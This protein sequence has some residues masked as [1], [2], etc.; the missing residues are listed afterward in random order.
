MFVGACKSCIYLR[1]FGTLSF[2]VTVVQQRQYL[3]WME[4][5][6]TKAKSLLSLL[7]SLALVF[8]MVPATAF[9]STGLPVE[10]GE[11]TDPNVDGVIASSSSDAVDADQED[12]FE[13]SA[14]EDSA[15]EDLEEAIDAG[16]RGS[17]DDLSFVFI[18]WDSV[19]R[20]GEQNIAVGFND[21]TV[22]RDA[23]LEFVDLETGATHEVG[24]SE[25]LPGALK[26][27]FDASSI[28]VGDYRISSLCYVDDEGMISFDLSEDATSDYAF[29]IT[30]DAVEIVD[31]DA[32]DED[33]ASVFAVDPSGELV[34]EDSIGDA[35]VDARAA[36]PSAMSRSRSGNIIVVLDPGHGGSEPGTSGNGLVERDVN[37]KIAKYCRDA[38]LGY[39]GVEVYMTRDSD[40]NVGLEERAEIAKRLH[41]NIFVSIHNNAATNSSA[42]GSEVIVPLNG[43]GTAVGERILDKLAALGLWKRSVYDK[44]YPGNPSLDYY[45]V[46]RNTAAA[47][48]PGIIIEHAF[49][50]NP[51]D[52]AFLSN[53]ANL[54]RLG[55][56][57]AAG[58]AEHYGL[59]SMKRENAIAFVERLYQKVLGRNPDSGG[60]N[61]HVNG[62]LAGVSA[63]DVAWVFF[64]SP[65]FSNK[66]LTTEQRVDIAYRTMLDRGADAGGLANWK[67]KLDVGMSMRSIIS[68]FSS[69][70]EFRSLCSRWGLNPG[71][72]AVVENRDK[73]YNATAFVSRLYNLVLG[74]S[75]DASGLNAHT[76]ALNAGSSAAQLALSFFTAPEFTKKGLSNDAV[77]EIAYKTMLNRASDANGKAEWLE[78]MN[79]GM[80]LRLL[81][82]GFAASQEFLGLCRSYGL[83][84]GSIPYDPADINK[85]SGYKI[86]GSSSNA[87]IQKMVRY[88][89][90]TGHRYPANS[91]DAEIAAAYKKSDAPNI[92]IFCTL[93]YN[94]A[95]SEGVK[96]EVVFCQAMKETGWLQFGGSVDAKQFNFAGLGAVDASAGGASFPT[97][98]IGL[99]A[100]VQHLKCYA[101]TDPLRNTC[102]DPRWDNVVQRYG[103]GCA[104]TLEALNGRWAVPGNGYGQSI[105]S[106]IEKMLTL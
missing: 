105:R 53:E 86:M 52:A 99:R 26:F 35:L 22:A 3:S 66:N 96:P 92:T 50:S 98:A 59:S 104:P 58:I 56:A 85:Y 60:L 7:L 48:I 1:G 97:V 78:K 11:Q 43:S 29:S 94:E 5:S 74:R 89:Q 19:P 33:G 10:Q 90:S 68:G 38:L 82:A 77:I 17:L 61:A 18:E 37:L 49:I 87:V 27:T 8:C 23:V 72:L 95:T 24:S 4:K 84:A 101:S 20:S 106:M 62:L 30:D 70:P 6:M 63:S 81:I 65:E 9:A 91:T 51:D 40:V 100:Q 32:A 25:V 2:L 14:S 42:R 28:G 103:R 88:F 67:E 12:G 102:V 13:P 79:N 93:V 47:G 34:E 55:A 71:Y 57:D 36:A 15:I 44:E 16:R 75:G 73:N 83:S 45:S 46:I 64:S 80:P 76:G 21:E 39:D 41:A 69:S 54:Q 31:G